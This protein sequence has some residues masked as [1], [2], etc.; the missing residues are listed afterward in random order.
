MR[1]VEVSLRGRRLYSVT[2]QDRARELAAAGWPLRSIARTLADE[3]ALD[4]PP[5]VNTINE[6]VNPGLLKRRRVQ[7]RMR[8][9]DH[10]RADFSYPGR[11]S[12]EWKMGRIRALRDGG[13]VPSGI[14]A[15]MAL[16]F[17]DDPLLTEY[18][19][20]QVIAGRV[21]LKLRQTTTTERN[22]A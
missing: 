2:V 8:H 22:A 17:P 4:K 12:V 3:F 13:V 10:R 16:D 11:R 5:R 18:E 1:H 9:R 7:D 14:A 19:V 20:R 21:P 6:W 15:V